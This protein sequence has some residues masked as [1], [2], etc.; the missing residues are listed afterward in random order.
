MVKSIEALARGMRVIDEMSQKSPVTLSELHHAT[1]IS[2]A[3]LL[4]ILKTLEEAGWVFRSLGEARYR[5]SYT[6]SGLSIA[7][8]P[9]QVLGELAA[10][11]LNELQAKVR[12][13]VDIAVRDG[14]SMLIVETTRPMAAFILNRKV[15][16]YRPP[17]LFSGLGRAYLAFC[18]EEERREIL[19]GLRARGGREGKLARDQ[20]WLRQVLERTRQ[21]GYGQRE[22]A[23][24][25]VGTTE[26][27]QIEA[28]A[29]P[30]INHERVVATVSIAWPQG[31][32]SA[33]MLA[34]EIHPAAQAAVQRL[35]AV[36]V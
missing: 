23:Y 18:P 5:L 16:G 4:R 19:E 11:I 2:K 14:L 1:G 27:R 34:N 26:N 22:P 32:V 29:L 20:A 36:L 7:N 33:E 21:Q 15:M 31:S 3:T 28:I 24:F 9:V 8:D 30:V 35:A 12:W 25:G 13:P 10:P 6:V 17:F